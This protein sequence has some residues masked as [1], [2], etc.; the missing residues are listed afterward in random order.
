MLVKPEKKLVPRRFMQV[1]IVGQAES[2]RC[3]AG[4]PRGRVME[5]GRPLA[6]RSISSTRSQPAAN[7]INGWTLGGDVMSRSCGK[8][9]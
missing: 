8:P 2:V 1:C 3:S 7:G 9:R 6:A 5:R 4:D